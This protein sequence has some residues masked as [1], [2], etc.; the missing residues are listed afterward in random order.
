MIVTNQSKIQYDYTLP[1]G[2]TET[3][4]KLS[5][6]VETEIMTYAFT[7]VKSSDKTFLR[8]NEIANQKVTLTNSSTRTVSNLFFN[9]TLSSGG[10]YVNGSVIVNNIPQPTYNLISGFNLDDIAPSGQSTVEYQVIAN[11]P[12]SE[13]TLTNYATLNYAVDNRNLNE[14]TNTITLVLVSSNFGI[15]KEVDKTVAIKGETL[16][17]TTKI[18]NTGSLDGKNLI[19]SDEIPAG[20]TFVDNS[21]KINSIGQ[22][23]YNPETGFSLPDLAVGE[24]VTVEFDVVVI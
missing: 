15:V 6:I 24:S 9:D 13:D 22:P 7:K 8:E 19:F 17:Y 14:N 16:H 21:V 11:S 12:K 2:Q 10:T 23:G 1:D 20:T 5:N 4:T 18:T 3:A